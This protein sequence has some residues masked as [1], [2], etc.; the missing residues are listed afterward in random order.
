MES[1]EDEEVNL[2]DNTE[3]DDTEDDEEPYV[4]VDINNPPPVQFETDEVESQEINNWLLPIIPLD[5]RDSLV[6]RDLEAILDSQLALGSVF[7]SKDDLY[8]AVG[9]WHMEHRA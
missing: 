6:L 7:W 4:R 5:T 1:D 2:D 3:Y 9:L 8:I